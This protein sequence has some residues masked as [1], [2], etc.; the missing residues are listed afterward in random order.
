MSNNF[1]K[2]K[3]GKVVSLDRKW[4]SSNFDLQESLRR[5]IERREFERQMQAEDNKR[6]MYVDPADNR[7]TL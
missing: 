5:D 6:L 4:L 2:Q 3:L 1:R 7:Y